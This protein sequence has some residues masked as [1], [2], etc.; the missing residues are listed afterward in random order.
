MNMSSHPWEKNSPPSLQKIS[1]K[2]AWSQKIRHSL[3][4]LGFAVYGGKKSGNYTRYFTW[5]CMHIVKN[6][7][8]KNV[9]SHFRLHMKSQLIS[10]L[11]IEHYTFYYIREILII[12]VVVVI[13]TSNRLRAWTTYK[14]HISLCTLGYFL[15]VF[16]CSI[17]CS[18]Y[19]H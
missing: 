18:I 15:W 6:S 7:L 13:T 5:T 2:L 14:I 4:F 10:S 11:D 3:T 19:F 12:L 8:I 17:L 16:W 9:G 1:I